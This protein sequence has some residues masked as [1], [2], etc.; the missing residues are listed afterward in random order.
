MDTMTE[1]TH[2]WQLDDGVFNVP[3]RCTCGAERIFG[4]TANAGDDWGA[5]ITTSAHTLRD[6]AKVA[7][8]RA[9]GGAL[10]KGRGRKAAQ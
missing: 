10:A 2:R 8:S 3:G 4:R 9:R 6:A 5:S 1:H 7:A